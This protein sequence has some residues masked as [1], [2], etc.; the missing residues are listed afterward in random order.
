MKKIRFKLIFNS[1]SFFSMKKDHFSL[2]K[3]F[4]HPGAVLAAQQ[5]FHRQNFT[6]KKKTFFCLSVYLPG[7]FNFR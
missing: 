4:T 5:V 6:Q 1:V 7:K 3:E 2:L